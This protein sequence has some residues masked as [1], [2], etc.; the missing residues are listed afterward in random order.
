MK[1][2]VVEAP[3]P[4]DGQVASSGGIRENGKL[5]AQYKNPRPYEES[6][7][8]IDYEEK[9]ESELDY[10]IKNEVRDIFKTL[11]LEVVLPYCKKFINDLNVK[12]ESNEE[13]KPYYISK[14]KHIDKNEETQNVNKH[15]GKVVQFKYKKAV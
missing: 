12:I 6:L 10:A 15:N 14:S 1:K 13:V 9:V 7:E 4:K 2:Y 5:V 11:L 8:N 3:E